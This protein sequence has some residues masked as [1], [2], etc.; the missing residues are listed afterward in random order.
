MK[1]ITFLVA[2]VLSMGLCVSC[3]NTSKTTDFVKKAVNKYRAANE[4]DAIRYLK[5]RN[6]I[7]QV[8]KLINN[9]TSYCSTCNGYGVVYQIDEYGNVITDYYGNTIF[10][11]CPSCSEYSY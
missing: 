4:S 7:N 6:R 2:I 8:E 1:K 5:M 9:N 11:L 3:R 10:Y